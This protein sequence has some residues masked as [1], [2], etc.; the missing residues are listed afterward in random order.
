MALTDYVPQELLDE[1][2]FKEMKVEFDTKGITYGS[3]IYCRKAR[4][5]PQ[6]LVVMEVNRVWDDR[7]RPE[8]LFYMGVILGGN[9]TEDSEEGRELLVRKA[10]RLVKQDNKI[11]ANKME[12]KLRDVLS[13]IS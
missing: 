5:T 6:T 1:A 13:Q 8:N 12:E 2:G 7:K 9:P 3:K 4:A 10:K 11:P